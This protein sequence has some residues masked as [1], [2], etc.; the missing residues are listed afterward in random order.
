MFCVSRKVHD[1]GLGL[2]PALTSAGVR[3]RRRVYVWHWVCIGET[4]ILADIASSQQQKKTRASLL[5]SSHWWLIY[6]QHA[7]PQGHFH[8]CPGGLCDLISELAFLSNLLFLPISRE[9]KVHVAHLILLSWRTSNVH[10]PASCLY[11]HWVH[12][13]RACHRVDRSASLSLWYCSLGHSTPQEKAL[14]RTGCREGLHCSLLCVALSYVASHRLG[15]FAVF[16]AFS[17]LCQA[18]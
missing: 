7:L 9:L 3:L 17:S 18:L 2:C 11:L 1:V 14:G 13:G 5:M 8:S 15:S 10:P 16:L 12:P 4:P 6:E